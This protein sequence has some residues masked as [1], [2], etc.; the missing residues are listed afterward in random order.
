MCSTTEAKLNNFFR[1]EPTFS[2]L[3]IRLN[4]NV[5]SNL[6]Y[7]WYCVSERKHMNRSSVLRSKT[8]SLSILDVCVHA[9]V[10]VRLCVCD[11]VC[12]CVTGCAG[13]GCHDGEAGCCNTSPVSALCGSPE[14]RS[15]WGRG[16]EGMDMA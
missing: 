14:E 7:W 9:T 3:D 16:G 5:V 8:I 15:M 4:S 10:C 6:G 12:V 13:S 2:L 11:C 1:L